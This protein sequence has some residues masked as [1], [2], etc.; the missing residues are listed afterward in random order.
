MNVPAI[1]LDQNQKHQPPK[2]RPV[3][4]WAYTTADLANFFP[5]CS[6]G[7]HSNLELIKIKVVSVGV[8]HYLL[9]GAMRHICNQR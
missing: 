9:S 8:K 4:N 6:I 1:E 2:G 5:S 3:L 7:Y